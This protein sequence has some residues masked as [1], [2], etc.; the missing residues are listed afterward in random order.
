MEEKWNQ[1]QMIG[2]FDILFVYRSLPF[3]F[4]VSVKAERDDITK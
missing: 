3:M 2:I 1:V 4:G